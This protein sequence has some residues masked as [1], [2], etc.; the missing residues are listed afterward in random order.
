M[1]LAICQTKTTPRRFLYSEVLDEKQGY[2]AAGIEAPTLAYASTKIQ[3]LNARPYIPI[4]YPKP[5]HPKPE[6]LNLER[7]QGGAPHTEFRVIHC[8]GPK[9]PV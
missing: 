4:L 5:I 6:A 3:A 1:V 9:S 2:S 8:P 7:W